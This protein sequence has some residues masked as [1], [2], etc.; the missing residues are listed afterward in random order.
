MCC[1]VFWDFK[2]THT[3][4]TTPAAIMRYASGI[5]KNPLSINI[6]FESIDVPIN[7]DTP[8]NITAIRNGIDA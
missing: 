7:A 1:S 6:P 3:F 5:R 4:D 2:Y 8:K